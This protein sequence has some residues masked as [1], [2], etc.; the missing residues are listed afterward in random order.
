[1]TKLLPEKQYK[2]ATEI[3]RSG[4]LVAF[5][6]ET[7][8]G[9]GAD[10][11]N[12]DAI[13]KIFVA[14][15]RPSDNPLIVHFSSICHLG[16]YF[17]ISHTYKKV[18][19]RIKGA[20]TIILP[21]TQGSKVSESVLGKDNNVEKS[22]A[23]R[24][25]SCKFSRKFIKSC[26]VPISAPSANT[27]TRPSP[28][29]WQAVHADLDGKI[30]AI[31]CGRQ[32]QIGLESTVIKIENNTIHILRQGGVSAEMLARKTGL[33]VQMASG[34]IKKASPGTRYKHYAPN[35]PLF[36]SEDPS[37]TLDYFMEKGAIILCLTKNKGIYNGM[38]TITLGST[39]KKVGKNLYKALRDAEKLVKHDDDIIII[40]QMPDTPDFDTIRERIEKASQ[41]KIL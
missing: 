25:P 41:G 16:E 10:A 8:Y 27:S 17:E 3:I 39:A 21:Y 22:I 31:L 12:A 28:T 14:K 13:A 2:I 34:N 23:V 29:T 5:R 4:R 7:V 38:P 35:K 11:T 32:T 33:L 30:G 19:K 37:D 26:G 18:L 36:V 9:L 20:L 15:N 24:I 40:E 1:M 6:T